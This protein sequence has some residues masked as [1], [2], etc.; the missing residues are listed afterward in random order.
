MLNITALNILWICK[1]RGISCV[2]KHMPR[3]PQCVRYATVCNLQLAGQAQSGT[4]GYQTHV[5]PEQNWAKRFINRRERENVRPQWSYQATCRNNWTPAFIITRTWK[6]TFKIHCELFLLLL[7]ALCFISFSAVM[8]KYSHLKF[9]A[10][11]R[12]YYST[13]Y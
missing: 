11:M 9:V 7:A 5:I 4:A 10:G 13:F 2:R 3:F 6:A 12:L 8:V 1:V